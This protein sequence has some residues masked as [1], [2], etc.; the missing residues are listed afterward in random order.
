MPGENVQSVNANE[1]MP[2][3]QKRFGRSLAHKRRRY[4]SPRVHAELHDRGRTVA[5]KRIARLM[6]EV[7]LYAKR[8]RK[9]AL[10][11]R[12]DPSHPVA[13]HLLHREF[14]AESAK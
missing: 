3:L 14:T 7:G 10:T 11:T 6:R 1:K 8:T 9:R 12:R 13:P 5:R 2:D 4:G